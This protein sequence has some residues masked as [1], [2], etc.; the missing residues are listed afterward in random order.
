MKWDILKPKHQINTYK[1]LAMVL[2]VSKNGI[3]TMSNCQQM[4]ALTGQLTD[5]HVPE[6]LLK[7][8]GGSIPAHIQALAHSYHGAYDSG[9]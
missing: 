3:L 7:L 6:Q 1:D 8:F 2:G 5:Q 4:Y 9:K